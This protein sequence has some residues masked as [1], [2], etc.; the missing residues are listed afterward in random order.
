MYRH[1]VL[2]AIALLGAGIAQAGS[3]APAAGQPGSTAIS[4]NSN[5]I[6]G[7][8]TKYTSYTPGSNAAAPFIDPAQALGPASGVPTDVVSLGDGG[9]IVLTFAAPIANGAGAD[10]AV[11]ENSF[12]DNFLEV[13]FVDVSSDGTN[14]F[15]FPSFSQ[16]AN[17]VPAFGTL[18]PTNLDGL[19]G[20]YRGGFG[21]PFDL[22][23]FSSVAA[24][25]ITRITH[26]RIVDVLGDGSVKDS[27]GRPIYD[28][29]PTQMSGGFDLDGV[30]VMY[31]TAAPVPEPGT[32]WMIAAGAILLPLGA[33]HA[34]RRANR[35]AA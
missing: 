25:N 20:K 21:T 33:R 27:L 22:E 32:I 30:G 6:D 8:A 35:A 24:L 3:Y 13:A 15:R 16:T 7:W 34:R 1:I 19:A 18:D 4:M 31:F 14:F 9:S 11:F 2:G 10:F 17:P 12:A 26:I 23:V 5:T 28:P 29:T